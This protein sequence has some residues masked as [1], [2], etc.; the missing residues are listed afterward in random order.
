[1]LIHAG[2]VLPC[3][4]MANADH[5]ALHVFFDIQT[6]E[7][8][9]DRVIRIKGKSPV[10]L[11]CPSIEGTVIWCQLKSREEHFYDTRSGKRLTKK[12]MKDRAE[13]I[14]FYS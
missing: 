6:E 8:P 13:E 3:R 7:G 10:D 2:T 5:T 14:H 1:M 12:Q 4:L 11:F 9:P